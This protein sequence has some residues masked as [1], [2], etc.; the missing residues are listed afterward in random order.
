MVYEDLLLNCGGGIISEKDRV[1]QCKTTASICIG[2][3]GTGVTALSVLKG[4]IYQQLKPDHPDGTMPKYKGIQLL[5]ID[6]DD[7]SYRQF[8]G[9]CRL[10]DAEFFSIRQEKLNYLLSDPVGKS[11]IKNDPHLNWMEIDRINRLLNERYAF[12]GER[13]TGRYL[14]IERAATL[15]SKLQL[16]CT[17][18]M[19]SRNTDALTVYIFAGLSG[20]TGGGCFLDVCYLVR[21][22]IQM[23][24]WNGRIVGCFFTPDVITGKP[25]VASNPDCVAYNNSNGYA[26]MKELD[27]LMNLKGVHDYF[28]QDYAEG[29]HVKTQMPPVDLCY[30]VSTMQPDGQPVSNAF[31]HSV[32]VAAECVL[33]YLTGAGNEDAEGYEDASLF[34]LTGQLVGAT[35][36]VASIPRHH[37]ANRCYQLV[38]ICNAEVPKSQFLTYLAA[39]FVRQLHQE[40]YRPKNCMTNDLVDEFMAK[41]RLR[42]RD[43]FDEIIK[44][45]GQLNLPPIDPGVLAEQPCCERG[46]LPREWAQAAN[47]WYAQNRAQRKANADKLIADLTAYSYAGNNDQSLIGRL[48]RRLYKMSA[49]FAYGPYYVAYL[50]NNNG[51][52]LCAALTGEIEKAENQAKAQLVQI[53]DAEQW[54]IQCNQELINA[55]R[56]QRARA[57]E[58]F[59]EAVQNMVSYINVYEQC[60]KTKEVLLT[61]RDQ[62]KRLHD[63]F[64]CPFRELFGNIYETFEANAAYLDAS[65]SRHSNGCTRQIVGLADVQPRLDEVI[66]QTST[67][68]NQC[69]FI[70][71]LLEMPEMWIQGDQDRLTSFIQTHMLNLFKDEAGFGLGDYLNEKYP[72]IQPQALIDQIQTDMI[73]QVDQ[74]AVPM[75]RC[76]PTVDLNADVAWRTFGLS[77]PQHCA[78]VGTA[79]AEYAQHPD[80]RYAIRKLGSANRITGMRVISGVPLFAYEG[81]IILRQDYDRVLGSYAGFGIHLYAKTDR[82]NFK[83]W[84]TF[85]PVPVPYSR[86]KNVDPALIPNSE[87]LTELYRKAWACGVIAGDTRKDA[88]YPN[89]KTLVLRLS[90]LPEAPDVPRE[91]LMNGSSV[92]MAK[93]QELE[94]WCKDTL[95]R[96]HCPDINPDCTLVCL[97][98][99]EIRSGEDETV[100]L[101]QFISAPNIQE[102][103]QMEI[104]KRERLEVLL[105]QL[106]SLR[107]EDEDYN[108]NLDFLV[109]MTFSRLLR[110]TDYDAKPDYVRPVCIRTVPSMGTQLILFERSMRYLN[111]PLYQAFLVMQDWFKVV[112]GLPKSK[113]LEP[114]DTVDLRNLYTDISLQLDEFR[115]QRRVPADYLV[116]AILEWIYNGYWY[117][118]LCQGNLLDDYTPEEKKDIIRFYAELRQRLSAL[119]AESASWPKGYNLEQLMQFLG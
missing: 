91:S 95:N 100:Y 15:V 105:K 81:L 10:S 40:F 30:L 26:A 106:D 39:G 3:G 24:G 92:D 97:T 44:D 34:S 102:L 78:E 93:L 23:G 13:Q 57:Y 6:F 87:S 18:A 101:D 37:G 41:T 83:E 112:T 96:M 47:L 114:Y 98:A 9:K 66:N 8:G 28:E 90:N 19:R 113:E 76:D 33:S 80:R 88:L 77:V 65:Q 54:V 38:G 79:T 82:G 69:N 119:K 12:V 99:G 31:E 68:T 17:E 74:Q 52:D 53:P 16:I 84:R 110:F 43:V 5:G 61:F 103:A 59:Y 42:V 51:Q 49:D 35:R 104:R 75:F 94:D 60:V 36:G 4:K 115:R 56:G 111:F 107:M 7:N 29:I 73:S 22:V 109:W 14:L 20:N 27:Y 1:D 32:D 25:E 116:P 118:D 11:R 2:I 117:E 50:L 63:E 55:R 70:E 64:F 67:F 108:K 21:H 85:L 46:K 48:F 58:A 89:Q 71:A 45:E 72:G 86:A 62:V